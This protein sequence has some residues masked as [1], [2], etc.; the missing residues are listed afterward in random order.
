MGGEFAALS[1]ALLMTIPAYA[2]ASSHFLPKAVIAFSLPL[3]VAALFVAKDLIAPGGRWFG[4]AVVACHFVVLFSFL[5]KN[6]THFVHLIDL[7]IEGARLTAMLREQKEI[8]ERAVQLKTRFLAAAS[9][10]LRQPMHAISLYLGGLSELDLP[11]RARQVVSDARE[12]AQDMNDMFRSLLDISRL[13]SRQ[14]VPAFSVFSVG[15]MLRRMKREFAPLAHSRGVQLR[16]RVRDL[17]AYSDPTM[18]ERIAQNF[19]SNAVRYA[20]GGRVLATC[21]VVRGDTVRL[22]VYDTGKGIPVDQQQ[23][24]FDEF[25][26]LDTSKPD[27]T[28]G[29]GL[30]LSIVRRL[31]ET[32]R[33]PVHVRSTPGRGS[34]FAVDLPMVHVHV[35]QV[36]VQPSADSLAGKLVVLVDDETTILQAA[37]FVLEGAGCTV[38]CAKSGR[39]AIETLAESARVPDAII[40]DYE[41]HD[42]CK[43]TDVIRLLREEFNFEIPAMLVTGGTVGGMAEKSAREMGVALLYKPV[44]SETLKSSLGVLLKTAQH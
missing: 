16:L 10:D 29:L 24:I 18:A 12:C 32:L 43:G 44:E 1:V 14:A 21:R 5:R 20:A 41:L 6:W 38:K 36:P 23:V 8:A 4:F 17:H 9:H 34:M 19:I 22:A 11:E 27:H 31:T 30:G 3:L 42:E 40:C 39:E 33:V 15:A 2:V 37:S 7:D 28:G 26:R 13:E 35:S 25:R